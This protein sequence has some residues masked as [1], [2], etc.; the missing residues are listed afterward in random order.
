MYMFPFL[1]PRLFSI[2][3]EWRVVISSHCLILLNIDGF[4][5]GD[6]DIINRRLGE[7]R[8]ARL[9]FFSFFW[10]GKDPRIAV[11][12]DGPAKFIWFYQGPLTPCSHSRLWHSTVK[13]PTHSFNTQVL[14]QAWGCTRSQHKRFTCVTYAMCKRTPNWQIHQPIRKK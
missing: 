7:R 11:L 12:W 1:I 13:N 5:G 10:F 8:K 6:R 3:Q 4:I 14:I 2:C 9:C